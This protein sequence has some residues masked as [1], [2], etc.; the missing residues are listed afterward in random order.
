[1]GLK[2]LSQPACPACGATDGML[3]TESAYYIC[4][5]L[6]CPQKPIRIGNSVRE[7]WEVY[8]KDPIIDNESR[9]YIREWHESVMASPYGARRFFLRHSINCLEDAVAARL[10]GRITHSDL[11]RFIEL[12]GDDEQAP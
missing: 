4:R 3:G 11:Q 1:M 8:W 2:N 9:Y 5:N 6:H 7:F 10:F 12:F